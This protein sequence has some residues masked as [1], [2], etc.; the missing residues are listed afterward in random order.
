MPSFSSWEIGVKVNQTALNP[1]KIDVS[2]NV[3]MANYSLSAKEFINCVNGSGTGCGFNDIPGVV[4]SAVAAVGSPPTNALISGLLFTITYTAGSL[5]LSSILLFNYDFSLAGN[6]VPHADYSVIN[7]IYGNGQ[8]PIVDFT[9]TPKFPFLG[10]NVTFD[11]SA[12]SDP[13]PRAGITSYLWDFQDPAGPPPLSSNPIQQHVFG[14]CISAC[15]NPNGNQSLIFAV[16]LTVIDNL[17]ISNSKTVVIAV[18]PRSNFTISIV[19]FSGFGEVVQGMSARANVS[20][21]SQFRFSGV[22]TLSSNVFP[23]MTQLSLPTTSL[24]PLQVDL[25]PGSVNSSVLTVNTSSATSPGLYDITVVG[26]SGASSASGSTTFRVRTKDFGIAIFPDH[27]SIVRGSIGSAFVGITS[28][29]GFSGTVSLTADTCIG[30]SGF[31]GLTASLR[32]SSV[33]LVPNSTVGLILTISTTGKTPVG[34]CDSDLIG[35]SGTLANLGFF[36][37]EVL[38]PRSPDFSVSLSPP[39]LLV[40]EGSTRTS[41][42]TLTGTHGFS[43]SLDLFA[44]AC[45]G[46]GMGDIN[47]AV[48]PGHVLLSPDGTASVTLTVSTTTSVPPG[49]YFIIITLFGGG[50]FPVTHS[51]IVEI[52]V[53]PLS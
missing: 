50:P 37:V 30:S 15:L 18:N 25:K 35:T 43:G 9:W 28:L 12:S 1:V 19:W 23:E 20:L 21:S 29:F 49:N 13:N 26:T 46:S 27:L 53:P 22:V 44:F 52:K 32:T 33:V 39:S 24:D 14:N 40:P 38:S 7:A 3:L 17:T 8:L 10:D 11:A 41:T 34:V 47:A 5:N 42:I 45:C 48:S 16:T 51:A 4:T 6:S 31:G 2:G 36:E